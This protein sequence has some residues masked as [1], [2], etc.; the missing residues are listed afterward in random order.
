MGRAR[1]GAT[2]PGFTLHQSIS[3]RLVARVRLLLRAGRR[4]PVRRLAL[5][6]ACRG[7]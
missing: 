7:A 4:E 1:I 3:G 6:V 2:W 5:A